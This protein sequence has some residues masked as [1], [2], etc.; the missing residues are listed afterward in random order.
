MT[1]LVC[2][3]LYYVVLSVLSHT[4]RYLFGCL[5]TL[6]Y[7]SVLSGASGPCLV[8]SGTA[9]YRPLPGVTR[10]DGAKPKTNPKLDSTTLLFHP[11][12]PLVS[13]ALFRPQAFRVSRPGSLLLVCSASAPPDP[14]FWPVWLTDHGHNSASR[15][16]CLRRRNLQR[17]TC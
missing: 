7:C 6:S 13:S 12:P 5:R 4:C 16:R 11:L 1:H 8:L 2:T 15:D 17:S 10:T 3:S 9:L 14:A